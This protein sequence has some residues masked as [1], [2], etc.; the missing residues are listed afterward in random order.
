MV[1][2]S[3]MYFGFGFI[4]YEFITVTM[5]DQLIINSLQYTFNTIINYFVN[6]DIIVRLYITLFF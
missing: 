1:M 2:C 4:N 3:S 6:H 5:Y